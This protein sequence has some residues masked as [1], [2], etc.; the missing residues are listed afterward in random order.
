MI[1]WILPDTKHIIPQK[2]AAKIQ[3]KRIEKTN[4]INSNSPGV[5]IRKIISK[6]EKAMQKKIKFP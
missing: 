1:T 6:R 5:E 3:L 4:P 2:T